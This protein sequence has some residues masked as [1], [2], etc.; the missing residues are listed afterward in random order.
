MNGYYCDLANHLDDME[1]TMNEFVSHLNKLKIMYNPNREHAHAYVKRLKKATKNPHQAVTKIY[2]NDPTIEGGIFQKNLFPEGGEDPTAEEWSFNLGKKISG[3][4]SSESATSVTGT[5]LGA[6]NDAENVGEEDTMAN[7]MKKRQEQKKMEKAVAD[8]K[9]EA[10]RAE[11]IRVENAINE[12]KK[13][14]REQKLAEEKRLQKEKQR[15]NEEKKRQNEEKQSANEEKQ[16]EN[17]RKNDA[18]E[19]KKRD[20]AEARIEQQQRELRDRELAIQARLEE[21]NRRHQE[22]EVSRVAAQQQQTMATNVTV[23][24]S[25]HQNNHQAAPLQSKEEI[26]L[27]RRVQELER[28]EREFFALQQQHAK[29]SNVGHLQQQQPQNQLQNYVPG[30][31]QQ[32]SYYAAATQQSPHYPFI[33]QSP[34]YA[35]TPQHVHPYYPGPIQHPAL[36]LYSPQLQ[37]HPMYPSPDL[38]HCIPRTPHSQQMEV[39]SYNGVTFTIN[40]IQK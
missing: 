24:P 31:P 27:Q 19:A 4:E 18:S 28:R 6:A 25:T 36:A 1:E 12:Q 10:K 11:A 37:Q 32:S 9:V 21:L 13:I 8:K 3:A 39:T 23:A 34:F 33:Q 29:N 2:R 16:R 15:V 5:M 14:L 7:R 26:E 35:T 40:N 20:D 30:A 22:A 38:P 17:Q